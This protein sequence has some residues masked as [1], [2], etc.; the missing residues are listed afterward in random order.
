M[1]P[2]SMD[3][4]EIAGYISETFEGIDVVEANGDS[5]YFYDPGQTLR[6]DRRLPFA[7]LVTTDAH[8]QVSNLNRDGVY[9]LNIGVARETY[10]AL[11]GQ[12]PAAWTAAAGYDY[13]ALDQVL[14]HPVYGSMSWICVLNPSLETFTNTVQ[15]YLVEAHAQAAERFARRK[16]DEGAV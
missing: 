15:G 12:P 1:A 8:D 11:F 10:R 13:A 16:P 2:A 7:T 4:A 14:P 6:P 5:F 9:R 3:A